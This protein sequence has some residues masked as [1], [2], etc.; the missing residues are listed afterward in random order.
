MTVAEKSL[1]ATFNNDELAIIVRNHRPYGD[2]NYQGRISSSPSEAMIATVNNKL[3]LHADIPTH[4]KS[5]ATIPLSRFTR[6][7]VLASL[8]FLETRGIKFGFTQLPD[9]DKN[10]SYHLV[11]QDSDNPH[12]HNFVGAIEAYRDAI[13]NQIILN[14]FLTSAP[15]EIELKH[16]TKGIY[17]PV[18]DLTSAAAIV[19]EAHLKFDKIPYQHRSQ[20]SHGNVFVVPHSHQSQL[21]DLQQKFKQPTPA[22][23]PDMKAAEPDIT[24]P[25][26]IGSTP[27]SL[28][29]F[30]IISTENKGLYIPVKTFSP[31][32][33]EQFEALLKSRNILFRDHTSSQ[34]IDGEPI[35]NVIQLL[36]KDWPALQQIQMEIATKIDGRNDSDYFMEMAS[37]TCRSQ[38]ETLAYKPVEP[39]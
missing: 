38:L 6:E 12:R 19:L 29:K 37:D 1:S 25:V 28:P 2:N 14:R 17:I 10:L 22:P 18:A 5:K 32:Q 13:I 8:W 31:Q 27:E 35:G 15:Q 4:D 23:T 7:E 9:G 39:Q 26:D 33:K 21:E 30:E 20:S 36:H 34:E 24:I 16:T 11:L 3:N